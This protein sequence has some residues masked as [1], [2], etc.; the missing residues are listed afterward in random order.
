ML[1]HAPMR[2]AA[3]LI[4][5]TSVEEKTALFPLATAQERIAMFDRLP[6]AEQRR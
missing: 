3:S 2:H 5:K 4:D 1:E 6:S